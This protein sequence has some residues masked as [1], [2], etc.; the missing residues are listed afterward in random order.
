[1]NDVLSIPMQT[2]GRRL[3]YVLSEYPSDYARTQGIPQ[4]P[5]ALYWDRE[6]Y[7]HASVVLC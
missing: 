4:S 6:H 7:L 5:N 3:G 1:M 2:A